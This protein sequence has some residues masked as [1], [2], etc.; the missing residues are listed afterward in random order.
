[1]KE[2]QIGDIVLSLKGRDKQNTFLVVDIKDEFAYLVDG[3]VRKTTK[4]KKKNLKHIKKISDCRLDGLA[5]EIKNG[6]CIGN[7]RVYSQI[8]S[9]QN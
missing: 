6:Q 1:M 9:Q 7:K 3:K 4:P 2:I 5:N 8:K